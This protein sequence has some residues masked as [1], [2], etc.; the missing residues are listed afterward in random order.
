[1]TMT[2]F[3]CD[4]FAERLADY[5]ERD[6]DAATRAAMEAHASGCDDCGALLAELTAIRA[7]A[8]ALPALTPSHDLWSGIAERIETPVV[9]FGGR[10]SAVGAAGRW[11]KHPALLAA[12]LVGITAGVTYYGT[13]EVYESR[14]VPP[15]TSAAAPAAIDGTTLDATPTRVAEGRD[16]SVRNGP[17]DRG[18]RV[19]SSSEASALAPSTDRTSPSGVRS[20]ASARGATSFAS[21][22]TADR[23]SAI[24]ETYRPGEL[25]ALDSLYHREILRLREVLGERRDQLDS[26][27][28]AVLERNM[29]V[30]DRAI[31]ECRA[32]LAKDPASRFLNRQLNDALETK[33]ELLRTAATMPVG[34]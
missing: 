33:I 8:A 16:A 23:R 1:M 7:E 14:I 20:T 25:A 17:A 18:T 21:A 28:V 13:R 30:I 12:G 10:R 11:W 29:T 31:A 26:T 22:P 27:T 32:A 9:A 2:P 15:V 3:T 19:P 4:T 24:A 34:S 5:L 6:A